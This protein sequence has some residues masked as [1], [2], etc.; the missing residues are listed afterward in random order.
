M[1]CARFIRKKSIFLAWVLVPVG[2]LL[3]VEAAAYAFLQRQ[4]LA[5]AKN[6]TLREIIPQMALTAR[7]FDQFILSY[8]PAHPADMHERILQRINRAA[9]SA[10]LPLSTIHVNQKQPEGSTRVRCISLQVKGSGTPEQICA[11]L[12]YIKSTDPFLYESSVQLASSGRDRT[13]IPFEA[14]LSKIYLC[15]KRGDQ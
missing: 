11:F 4:H 5:Y 10:A 8:E 2:L 13:N 7:E 3:G 12:N 9:Q 15:E 14:V 1:N 6:Q